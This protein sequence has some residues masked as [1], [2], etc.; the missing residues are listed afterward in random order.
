MCRTI[1]DQSLKAPWL[2]PAQLV[3]AVSGNDDFEKANG[4]C[5]ISTKSLD[6]GA[7]PPSDTATTPCYN[8]LQ[9]ATAVATQPL[10]VALAVIETNL[11][12]RESAKVSTESVKVGVEN[13]LP[14]GA[15]LQVRATLPALPHSPCRLAGRLPCR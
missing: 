10:T 7:P 5:K 14:R 15:I 13:I 9:M 8:S 4:Q 3:E 12:K 2:P 1:V 6:G 11:K